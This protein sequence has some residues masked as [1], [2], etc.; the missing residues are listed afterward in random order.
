MTASA[1]PRQAPLGL[2]ERGLSLRVAACINVG[3]GL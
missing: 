1:T 2:F 3:I